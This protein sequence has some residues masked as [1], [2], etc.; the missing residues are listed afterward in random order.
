MAEIHRLPNPEATERE[1]SDWF[2][3]MNADDVTAA[4]RASFEAWLR[5]HPCNAKAYGELI[6]TWNLLV[7]SGPLVR[8]VYFGQAMNAASA[9]SA[10]PSRW[11]AAALAAMVIALVLGISWSGY[12]QNEHTRFQ[13]A[14]GE[15]VAVALPD[16]SSVNLNTNSLVEVD[17]SRGSRVIRLERGEAYFSVAHDTH[18]P[19]WVHAGD[20]WVRAVGTAFNVYLRPAGVQVTVSEGTVN[21]VNATGSE[22]PPPEFSYTQSA[23]AVTAGEQADAHGR[24]DVIRALNAAQLNRLL[25]WRKSTLYFQD[26]PLGDVVNELMRYTTLKI[27]ISDDSLR[28]V[29]VGG[30][31]QTSPEGAEALLTMLQD[32][33]GAKVRRVGANEVY[34]EGSNE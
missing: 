33:F 23:A 9:R 22:S 2:A 11:L 17:Y 8:A 19:F 16:G 21:V 26:E 14:I 13:T 25:A 18:R 10:R 12:Q 6:G 15:Q 29:P 24:A 3:R 30:T 7:K 20:H 5:M 32:G 34:I 4:D 1:A 31:F 28:Q 27:E